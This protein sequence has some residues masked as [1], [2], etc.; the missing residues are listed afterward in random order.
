MPTAQSSMFI[1]NYDGASGAVVDPVTGD[2][3]FAMGGENNDGGSGFESLVP[4]EI[5]L[6]TGWF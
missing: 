3:L 4:M 2:L 6:Q 1:G 5:G